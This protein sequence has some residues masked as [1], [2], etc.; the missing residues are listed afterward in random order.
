M[1]LAV[2]TAVVTIIVARLC[3]WA[4]PLPTSSAQQHAL[5][6]LLVNRVVVVHEVSFSHLIVLPKQACL[7][8]Q[9]PELIWSCMS[10]VI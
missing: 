2:I 10:R 8:S 9:L 3:L 5:A 1:C 4:I 7:E 6:E